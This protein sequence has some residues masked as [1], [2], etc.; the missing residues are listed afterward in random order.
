MTE[1]TTR[2]R[3]CVKNT[4]NVKN[5]FDLIDNLQTNFDEMKELIDKAINCGLNPVKSP[6]INE[7]INEIA[8]N[9]IYNFDNSKFVKPYVKNGHY[10]I[11]DNDFTGIYLLFKFQERVVKVIQNHCDAL[12]FINSLRRL[13]HSLSNIKPY[14]GNKDSN[15]KINKYI[16]QTEYDNYLRFDCELITI[17]Y[18]R[19]DIKFENKHH[20]EKIEDTIRHCVIELITTRPDKPIILSCDVIEHFE[21]W[22]NKGIPYKQLN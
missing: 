7:A 19:L 17:N 13:S 18:K 16:L 21:D 5:C 20:Y 4:Y 22:K 6:L 10:V 1:L 15:D 9:V 14:K 2:L 8:H 3:E 11:T 12:S